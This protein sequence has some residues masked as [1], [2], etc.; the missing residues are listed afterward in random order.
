M[1]AICMHLVAAAVGIV[2]VPE[3]PKWLYVNQRWQDCHSVIKR[4]AE[5]NGV[6]ELPQT[7]KLEHAT[8]I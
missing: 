2:F 3:S 6:K 4:M 5:F 7:A 1:W 8:K